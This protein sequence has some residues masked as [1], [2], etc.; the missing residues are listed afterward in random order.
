M[1][2]TAADREEQAEL[3][4]LR[5][6][7]DRSAAA[8]AHTLAELTSR[9]TAAHPVA[10]ARRV[11]GGARVTA[12]RA[13]REGPGKIAGQRGA[14]RLALTAIPVFLIAGALAYAVIRGRHPA[15]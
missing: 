10:V 11:A 8:A 7:A 12:L 1:I 4:D 14:K 6:Q 5:D 15:R 9:L 13:V 3:N 2:R